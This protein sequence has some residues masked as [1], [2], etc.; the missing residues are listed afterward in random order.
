M[1]QASKN[2][3]TQAPRLKNVT[4]YFCR[5]LDSFQGCDFWCQIING[6]FV[7]TAGIRLCSS[8]PAVMEGRR[9]RGREGFPPL[10]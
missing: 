2:L 9:G 7:C 4:I 3:L 8:R 6:V 5:E 10:A 1:L